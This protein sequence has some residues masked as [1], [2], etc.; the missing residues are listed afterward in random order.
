MAHFAEIDD[1]NIV[2]R[3]VVT[4]NDEPDE[5]Y[6]WLINN[7]GGRWIKT[8]YNTMAGVHYLPSDIVDEEGRRIPSGKPHLR[9][10]F[11]NIGDV[12]D[13]ERDAFYQQKPERI[14]KNAGLENERI[15]DYVLNE[16]T[17]VWERIQIK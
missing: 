14:V 2:L 13:E 10:N 16:D 12:Y 3:T 7:L 8:S 4:S 11:A 5:G 9:F 6:S 1:N 17:C 15:Y